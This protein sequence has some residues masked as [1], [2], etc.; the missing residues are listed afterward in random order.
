MFIDINFL[1]AGFFLIVMV[2]L[3]IYMREYLLLVASNGYGQMLFANTGL[4]LNGCPN[5]FNNLKP[6]R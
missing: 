2:I 6:W 1:Y 4:G 3:I 5:Y